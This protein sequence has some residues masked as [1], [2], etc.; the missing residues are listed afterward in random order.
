MH[1]HTQ[2][3]MRQWPVDREKCEKREKRHSMTD[4]SVVICVLL[5]TLFRFLTAPH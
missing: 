5:A 4:T 2:K 3:S 1:A